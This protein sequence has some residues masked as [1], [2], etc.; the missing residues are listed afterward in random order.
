MR[1]F[2]CLALLCT[3]AGCDLTFGENYELD[4]STFDAGRG[5]LIG[6]AVGGAAG[7]AAGNARDRQQGYINGGQ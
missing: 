6:A 3:I 1:K 4:A 2:A 5:A 7:A